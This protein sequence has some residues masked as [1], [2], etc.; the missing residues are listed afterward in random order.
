MGAYR[1]FKNP[2][3]TMPI[4]LEAHRQAVIARMAAHRLGLVPQDTTSINDTGHRNA[5]AMG[6]IGSRTQGGPI[7]LI[8]PNSHAFTL[9]GV[10]LGVVSA[11]VWARD[12]DADGSQRPLHERESRKWLDAY[13]ALQELAPQVPET[14]L[15][16]IGDREAE[17]FELFAL[18]RDPAS[19]RLLI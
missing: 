14:T 8:M 5:E 11:E 2:K 9:E 18:A 17:L 6:P 13:A 3:V 15:V 12:P 7:G 1:F 4:L 19:P 10:P 16:S